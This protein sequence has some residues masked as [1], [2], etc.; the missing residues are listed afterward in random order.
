[1]VYL[2]YYSNLY[3]V[4]SSAIKSRIAILSKTNNHSSSNNSVSS[5][6]QIMSPRILIEQ[7]QFSS[8][9]NDFGINVSIP[10][11]ISGN[12]IHAKQI[13]QT[14]LEIQDGIYI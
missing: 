14:L 7:A 13:L 8:H 3:N 11:D 1:M 5:W 6:S 10:H 12:G 2:C 4:L 9:Q